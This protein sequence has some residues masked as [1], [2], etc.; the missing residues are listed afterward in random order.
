MTSRIPVTVLTGFLGAGKTTLVN[1]ILGGQHGLRVCVIENEFGEVGVDQALV[2]QTKEELFELNNGCVCCTVRGDLIRILRKLLKRKQ[3]FDA[4]LI[5]T[6]GLADP[7]PVAQ[8]FFV[9][10]ELKEALRLDAIITVVDA[11]HAM[12]HLDNIR[13]DKGVNE[14]VQ[15]IAFADKL[16]LNKID[17]VNADDKH[18]ILHR[19]QAINSLVQIIECER[20]QVDLRQVLGIEA[21]DLARVVTL[22]PSFLQDAAA[23]DHEHHDHDHHNHDHADGHHAA[24]CQ[25]RSPAE[26]THVKHS[27]GDE[28]SSVGMEMEGELDPARLNTWLSKLL[29]E[30]GV[31]I[32]RSKGIL[33]FHG[34]EDKHVFQGVHMQ[35]EFGSSREGMTVANVPESPRASL[36]REL[37]AA[38]GE[39]NPLHH[40]PEDQIKD[41]S[42]PQ[43][44]GSPPVALDLRSHL[45]Q[46]VKAAAFHRQVLSA[47]KESAPEPAKNLLHPVEAVADRSA[48]LIEPGTH[49]HTWD[50]DAFLQEIQEG[51]PKLKH[52]PSVELSDRS[53]P[54]VE[55]DVHLQNN[56]H[57]KLLAEVQQAAQARIPTG[58]TS[59]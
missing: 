52:V 40:L 54:T 9:D 17:L 29:Q 6:T 37:Q 28:V 41:R 3:K 23:Q 49:V 16:L 13:E 48:P 55:D 59:Q 10:D 15:Q 45:L 18:K 26:A 30:H 36:L 19:I 34:S 32:Y 4:I 21:F 25:I 31:D 38:V 33:C 46:E 7:A 35:M 42:S 43:L 27:H 39:S 5:E 1:H 56:C 58:I 22:D 51:S 12:Q 20:A 8:T 44:E 11:K 53:E 57:A 24:D 50:R 2:M 47:I 14:A